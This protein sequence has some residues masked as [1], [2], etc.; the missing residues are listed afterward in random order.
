MSWWFFL[1]WC[2]VWGH[3]EFPFWCYT[4]DM[5]YI[6]CI[7]VQCRLCFVWLWNTVLYMYWVFV[8]HV[9][10]P[11]ERVA[12]N[13][14]GPITPASDRGHQYVLTVYCMLMPN[15]SIL[16]LEDSDL[17]LKVRACEYRHGLINWSGPSKPVWNIVLTFCH[18]HMCIYIFV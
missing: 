17:P 13:L 8:S 12:V 6:F 10:T 7:M 4:Y 9:G 18:F 3:S 2:F 14:I 5:L 11:F 15:A 16:I 1:A